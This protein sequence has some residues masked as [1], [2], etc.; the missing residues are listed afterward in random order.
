MCHYKLAI[1]L[2]KLYNSTTMT[3]DWISL[4]VQQNFNGRN[5]KFQIFTISNY[6]VGQNL[7][8]N[9][10]KPLNNKIEYNWLNES[11]NSFKIKCKKLFLQ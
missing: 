4:N 3:D 7:M 8:V 6:K 10:F 1:Q 5:N 11:L 2:H 9:K